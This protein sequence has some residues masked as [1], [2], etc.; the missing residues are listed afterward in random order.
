VNLLLD[1]HAL[2]WW[3]SDDP[4]LGASARDAI[5]DTDNLVHVSAVSLWEIT[6]KQGLG[7]LDLPAD[8][9]EALTAQGFRELPMKWEH[10]RQNRS[11]PWL[12]RDPFDRMLVAQAQV[13]QLTLVTDDREIREYAVTCL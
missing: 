7:K 10:A 11:L 2:L 12:H 1:T 13:E 3:L 9:E 6:I 8:F 4:R 5:A